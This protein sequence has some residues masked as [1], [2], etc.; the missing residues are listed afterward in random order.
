MVGIGTGASTTPTQWATHQAATHRI[1]LT[2][3]ATGTIASHVVRTGWES[4]PFVQTVAV[5]APLEHTLIEMSPRAEIVALGT[6][7][8]GA[9]RTLGALIRRGH[10]NVAVIPKAAA[11]SRLP[12]VVLIDGD[13][14]SQPAICRAI[15]EAS[16]R[17][18]SLIAIHTWGEP[19]HLGLPTVNWS[20]IEWANNREQEREVLAER[21]AGYQELYPDVPIHRITI[22]DS[23]FDVF[24]ECART[25]Q[26][27]VVG[28]GRNANLA[29]TSRESVFRRLTTTGVPVLIAKR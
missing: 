9:H 18:V 21:L 25:A 15:D 20:P 10:S 1:P 23:R 2:L 5:D 17:H 22:S 29:H 4:L 13:P 12:V 11:D 3:V 8:P 6:S 27:I 16:R 24:A 28:M 19:G 7:D 14:S 26:L